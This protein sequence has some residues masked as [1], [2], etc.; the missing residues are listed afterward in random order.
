MR[1]IT[2]TI[3]L[4]A[5]SGGPST[6]CWYMGQLLAAAQTCVTRNPPVRPAGIAIAST[7]AHPLSGELPGRVAAKHS[8]N[9]PV[10]PMKAIIVMEMAMI[11][12]RDSIG[13]K[14]PA[15][16]TMAPAKT[17]STATRLSPARGS[18][19]VVAS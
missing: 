1:R 14:C 12:M 17:S 2:D 7:S 5:T 13:S 10:T 18:V 11:G 15:P 6:R 8:T 9:P 19:D 4:I 3:T 16:S